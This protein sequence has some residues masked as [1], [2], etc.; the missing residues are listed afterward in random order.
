MK[1]FK[2]L[3][4]IGLCLVLAL[5]MLSSVAGADQGNRPDKSGFHSGVVLNVDGEDYYFMGPPIEEEAD[6]LDVPGHEWVVAGDPTELSASITTPAH[7][8]HHSGNLQTLLT[9]NCSI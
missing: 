6:E 8:E 5:F 7:L 3:T 4:V 9:D 1:D 2:K